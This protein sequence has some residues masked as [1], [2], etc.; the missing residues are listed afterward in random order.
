MSQY[1]INGQQG[2]NS[3]HEIGQEWNGFKLKEGEF[4]L[5]IGKEFLTVRVVKL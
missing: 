5:D 3:A 2:K 1:F 4:R